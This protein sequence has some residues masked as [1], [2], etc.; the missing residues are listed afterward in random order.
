MAELI[1]AGFGFALMNVCFKRLFKG[2]QLIRANVWQLAGSLIVLVP[3]ALLTTPAP[4]IVLGP[5]LFLVL[6][7]VGGIGT[8][9]VYVAFLT[10]MT[11]Y[12]VSSLTAYFFLVVV[13]ALV[14]SY[15]ISGETISVLQLAGVIA[16]IVAIYLV[17]QSDKPKL[18][19]VVGQ[20]S[21]SGN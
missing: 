4:R 21:V 12:S 17:G 20:G 16:I 9:L 13:V 14:S 7:W 19:S 2:G 18:S 8:A 3:W 10:L 5:E 11:R 15:F 1:V 6:I